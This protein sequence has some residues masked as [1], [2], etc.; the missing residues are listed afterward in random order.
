[1]A[2]RRAL[3]SGLLA[4]GV[5]VAALASAARASEWGLIT[6]G[7]TTSEAVR[8]RYGNATRVDRQKVDGFDTQSWVYEAAQA[9]TGVERMTV[10]FGLKDASGYRP[11]VVRDFKIEPRPGTFNR[12]IIV[13]GWGPP[14]KVGRDNERDIFLYQEGLLVYFDPEGWNATLMVFTLPQPERAEDA[15]KPKP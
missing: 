8:G 7:Q 10:E 2:R 3:A 1:M 6:P 9:P 14:D 15:A 12:G 5:L 11:D 13:S 4:L